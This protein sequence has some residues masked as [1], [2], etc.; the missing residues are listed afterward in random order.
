M[1]RVNTIWALC[2]A[3]STVWFLGGA[4]MAVTGILVNLSAKESERGKVHGCMALAAGLGSLTGSLLSGYLVDGFGFST[5][6]ALLSLVAGLWPLAALFLREPRA[7]ETK[8][9]A[10]QAAQGGRLGKRF[11]LL[12]AASLV[13]AIAGFVGMMGRSMSMDALGYP[14]SAISSTMA[15]SSALTL[16]LPLLI[17]WLSDRLGRKRF[18]VASYLVAAVGLTVLSR[19]SALW[20]FAVAVVLTG[21]SGSIRG[22]VGAALA[23]D[24]IPRESLGRGLGIFSSTGWVGAIVGF[25]GTGQAV[26]HLGLTATLVGGAA[27]PLIALLLLVP[28]RQARAQTA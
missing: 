26:Q 23:D 25:A 11:Y 12:S 18:L 22:V 7:S 2:L 8:A 28:L 15:L 17:G 16:P 19:S 24:L 5:M 21:L 10:A 14:A 6:F 4:G 20:H 3:T 1:G 27:L 9:K 13:I